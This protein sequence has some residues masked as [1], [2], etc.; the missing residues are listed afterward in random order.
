MT[1]KSRRCWSKSIGEP[2]HRVRLYEHA[3]DEESL[4]LLSRGGCRSILRPEAS[5]EIQD[6][7]T[8]N[9]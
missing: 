4:T 8:E 2:G 3:L 1:R 6:R 7:A 9:G 5:D